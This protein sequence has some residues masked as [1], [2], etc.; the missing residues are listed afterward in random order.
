LWHFYFGKG[1]NLGRVFDLL[2][3]LLPVNAPPV[4]EISSFQPALW[5][6]FSLNRT[7]NAGPFFTY[8]LPR[9]VKS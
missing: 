6:W 1:L 4:V 8:H 9:Q 5:G 2:R 7:H 3:L